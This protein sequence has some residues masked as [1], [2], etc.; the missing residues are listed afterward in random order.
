MPGSFISHFV[1]ISLFL[2]NVYICFSECLLH[3][4]SSFLPGTASMSN[5]ARATFTLSMRTV[6]FPC[7]RSRTKRKPSPERIANSSWVSPAARRLFFTN[8]A[9]LF[10]CVYLCSLMKACRYVVVRVLHAVSTSFYTFKG[11]MSI[12]GSVFIPYGV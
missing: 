4:A 8:S 2:L 11:I 7:S 6:S 12:V 1:C 5:I 9:I 10:M 3:Q